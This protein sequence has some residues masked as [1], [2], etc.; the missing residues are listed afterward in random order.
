MRGNPRSQHKKYVLCCEFLF[1]RRIKRFIVAKLLFLSRCLFNR[2]HQGI[3]LW[4]LNNS[5]AS[6]ESSPLM[7]SQRELKN[8]HENKLK[9]ERFQVVRACNANYLRIDKRSQS[10]LM[11]LTEN[12]EFRQT[13]KMIYRGV[14]A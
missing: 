2:T 9:A 14:V 13:H 7:S 3:L 10:A 4:I 5:S 11:E 1:A 8:V 6:L 12:A